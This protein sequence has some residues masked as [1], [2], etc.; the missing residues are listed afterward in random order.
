MQ[1]SNSNNHSFIPMGTNNGTKNVVLDTGAGLSL[2]FD[3]RITEFRAGDGVFSP[4]GLNAMAAMLDQGS[5]N[6]LVG[7]EISAIL[8]PD[9]LKDR[10]VLIDFKTNEISFNSPM[11]EN[12]SIVDIDTSFFGLPVLEMSVN[13]YAL[14]TAFDT[15]ARYPF[16][17]SWKKNEVNL[18][19]AFE[20]IEDYNPFK[21]YFTADLH[22]GNIALGTCEFAD[23]TIAVGNVYD[24]ASSMV[25]V[26]AFLGLDCLINAGCKLWL[27]YPTDM[28]AIA[29]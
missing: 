26:D 13:G 15:G 18:G 10:N 25:H 4:N 11:P 2:C 9:F 23:T 6:K 16:V 8:G 3:S 20:Q 24:E 12:A 22:K 29:E 27:S 14:K 17:G 19:N 28:M 1:F 21:G 7:M 5:I